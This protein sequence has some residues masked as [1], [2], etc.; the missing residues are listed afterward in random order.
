[1]VWVL[2]DLVRGLIQLKLVSG[3]IGQD[4]DPYLLLSVKPKKEIHNN[5]MAKKSHKRRYT[6]QQCESFSLLMNKHANKY[7]KPQRSTIFSVTR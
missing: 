2:A 1:M 3:K 4:S 5:K 6:L 7:K